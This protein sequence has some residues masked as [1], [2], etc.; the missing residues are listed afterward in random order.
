MGDKQYSLMVL[1]CARHQ[2]PSLN[3]LRKAR[4]TFSADRF[5]RYER[6]RAARVLRVPI[7]VKSNGFDGFEFSFIQ[8]ARL[9]KKIFRLGR[10][11]V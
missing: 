1:L 10:R 11:L 4:I 2:M 7:M 3:L 6:S 8:I 5:R 9:L